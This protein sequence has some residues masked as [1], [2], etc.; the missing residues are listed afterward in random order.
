M[1][2]LQ[3]RGR[4]TDVPGVHDMRR[5][6]RPLTLRRQ[7]STLA[8]RHRDYETGRARAMAEIPVQPVPGVLASR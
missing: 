2:G 4:V 6:L 7:L 1:T 8:P 3:T 5:R